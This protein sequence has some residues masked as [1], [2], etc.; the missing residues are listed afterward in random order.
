MRSEVPSDDGGGNRRLNDADLTPE[1]RSAIEARRA[2]R[3]SS[4]Y[5]DE[6]AWDIEAYR[7]EYPPVG[8]PDSI[9][10]LA[11]V[12]RARARQAL[13]PTDIAERTGSDR[14]MSSKL[15]TGKIANP[16]ISAIA[17]MLSMSR[18]TLAAVVSVSLVPIVFLGI[19][20]IWA[21][22]DGFLGS[23]EVSRYIR[24]HQSIVSQRLS[25]PKVHSFTLTHNPSEWGALLIKFDVDD[26]ATYE[27]LESDLD[28]IWDL[29]FPPWWEFTIRNK[30]DL[31]NNWGYAAWGLAELGE[32]LQRAMI[33]GLVALA[34][35]GLFILIAVRCWYRRGRVG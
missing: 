18:P 1:Q 16:P 21:K 9:E 6:L 23:R 29:R 30:E 13:K 32:G 34:Q 19:I 8:D 10:P 26:K 12:G 25:D 27:M 2:E 4:E 28:D 31:G 24:D 17:W 22:I 35:A 3:Q 7:Q 33:A 15:K 20:I 11:G 14:A 5:Q